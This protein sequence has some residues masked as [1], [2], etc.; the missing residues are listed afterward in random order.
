MTSPWEK[1][2]DVFGLSGALIFEQ[3]AKKINA[4]IIL[5]IQFHFPHSSGTLFREEYKLCDSLATKD[6]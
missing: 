6:P 5:R 2:F 4:I 3:E 1:S